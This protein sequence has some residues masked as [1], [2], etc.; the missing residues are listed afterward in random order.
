VRYFPRSELV[1]GSRLVSLLSGDEVEVEVRRKVVDAAY[2]SPSTPATTPPPFQV[3]PGARCIPVHR[4]AEIGGAPE[5]FVIIGAGKTAMDAC[6]WLLEN[7]VDPGR[8]RWIKPRETW[9]FNRRFFQPG[10]LAG[11]I[12]E[13]LALQM[14]AA[15][16][17]R[18]TNDLFERIEDTEVFRRVDRSVR[19]TM[20]KAATIADWEIELLRR[21]E[22]VVRLGY[23]RRIE[24]NRIVLDGG[25]VPTTPAHLHVHCAA[26]GLSRPPPLPTFQ[27]GR[28]TL[29]AVRS[30]LV[31]F[32]AALVA[33]VEAHREDDEEKNRL[34]PPNPFPD[35]PLDWARNMLVHFQ[36]E[37]AWSGEADVLAWLERCRLNPTRGLRARAAEPAIQRVTERFAA[38]IRPG[39]AR[40][41]ELTSNAAA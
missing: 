26:R 17:A 20:F 24:R 5:G 1:G 33:F 27:R 12:V 37:R 32:N 2:L 18:S 39:L 8:V 41:A 7:G 38:S 34:C 31:P 10:H 11:D 29:Q 15:A 28:I 13:G 22:G 21:I 4:L 3:D 25:E 16:D 35:E 23:V 40:L 9:L 6:V 30:G 14:E 36:A 19:P